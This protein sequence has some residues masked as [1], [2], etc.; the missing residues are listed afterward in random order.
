MQRILFIWFIFNNF[1]CF[2]R[3]YKNTNETHQWLPLH[4]VN[5]LLLKMEADCVRNMQSCKK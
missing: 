5:K 4:F 1:T 3:F 2:G